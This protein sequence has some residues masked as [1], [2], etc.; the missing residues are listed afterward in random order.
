MGI[1]KIADVGQEATLTITGCEQVEGQFG[2]QVRFDA[3]GET[4]YLPASSALNQL[5]HIGL[6]AKQ[7]R[8]GRAH[9]V[10]GF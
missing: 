10:V 9:Y 4:L 5:A 3:D 2:P 6:F 1:I 7:S 8:Y